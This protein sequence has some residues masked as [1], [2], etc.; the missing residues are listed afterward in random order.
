MSLQLFPPSSPTIPPGG[1]VTQQLEVNNPSNAA[2]KMRLK[3]SFIAEGII[4][5]AC[6]WILPVCIAAQRASPLRLFAVGALAGGRPFWRQW[7]W[8]R[9]PQ[10]LC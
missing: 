1:S 5:A 10:Y 6:L 8:R 4:L 9:C 3:I 2:L 7:Q